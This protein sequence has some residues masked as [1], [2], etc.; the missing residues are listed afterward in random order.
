VNK[1][2]MTAVVK[3]CAAKLG[4]IPTLDELGTMAGLTK[5]QIRKTLGVYKHFV[6]ASGMEGRG[7]GHQVNLHVLFRDWAGVVRKLGKIPSVVEYGL[8]GQYTYTPMRTRYRSWHDVPAAMLAYARNEG[9]EEEWRDV[10]TIIMA[11]LERKARESVIDNVTEG[12]IDGVTPRHRVVTGQPIYGRPMVPCPLTYAPTCE[13][14]V[15]FLF[16]MVAERLG[17][18]VTKIQAS[19]PDGEA[20]RELAPNRWQKVRIEFE[21]ESRNFLAHMHPTTGCDV[22]VCWSHNWP[23]CP[24][25]VLELQK[26]VPGQ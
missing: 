12:V 26:V 10:A 16:G 9:I 1:E 8:H 18:A 2:E 7:P 14:A 3:D 11:H 5:K 25:E 6:A 23:E 4:R 13:S 17:Y 20:L 22:I 19:F 21:Y 24:L 15:V